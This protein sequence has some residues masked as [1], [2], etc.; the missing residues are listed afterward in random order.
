MNLKKIILYLLEWFI[1]SST[2][3][4]IVTSVHFTWGTYLFWGYPLNLPAYAIA[5]LVGAIIYYPLNKYVFKNNC[6]SI[7]IKINGQVF[8]VDPLDEF[9]VYANPWGD[10]D[11][12]VEKK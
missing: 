12:S 5:S 11:I 2:A 3:V 7:K 1:P 9:E 8:F 6:E 4:Y 10:Y